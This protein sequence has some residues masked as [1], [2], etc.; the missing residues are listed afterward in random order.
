MCRRS[1]DAEVRASFFYLVLI[2][3][4]GSSE[5]SVEDEDSEDAPKKKR[6]DKGPFSAFNRYVYILSSYLQRRPLV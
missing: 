1:A 5:P 6:K 3:S 2:L 4:P